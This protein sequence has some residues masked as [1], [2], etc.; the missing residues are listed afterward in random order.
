MSV[1]TRIALLILLAVL[2]SAMSLLS[3]SVLRP[4]PFADPALRAQAQRA[5]LPQRNAALRQVNELRAQGQT[6]RA[7]LLCDQVLATDREIFGP[8]SPAVTHC[9]LLLAY[10]HL[11]RREFV[12]ARLAVGEV[13]DIETQLYGPESWRLA[14]T[15]SLAAN[16]ER[17]ATLSNA[18]RR[19]LDEANR[20]LSE[21]EAASARAEYRQ[22]IALLEQARAALRDLFG[23]QNS[24]YADCLNS[25]VVAHGSCGDFAGAE[26]LAREAL[27]I[28]GRVF[29]EKHP[30]YA[31]ILDNLGWLYVTRAEYG[32]AR[33][34][35]EQALRVALD[36]A[37]P[38]SACH[39]VALQQLARFH[40]DTGDLLQA[41]SLLL[42]ALPL[43]E[44]YRGVNPRLQGT[45][46]D[47]LGDLYTRRG[48][49]AR[50]RQ[51]LD[52]A[53]QARAAAVG[54][55]HPDYAGTLLALGSWYYR[56][57][58]YDQAA[59]AMV[60]ALDVLKQA[61]LRDHPDY[62]SALHDAGLLCLNRGYPE[63]ARDLLR[64]AAE[65][66]RKV[67]GE[68]HP[69]YATC[70]DSLAGAYRALGDIAQ[71]EALCREA[72]RITVEVQGE[73]THPHATRLSN[74]GL[75][76]LVTGN[77]AAA[78]PLL[79][80]AAAGY[81]RSV[82][83]SH[84]DYAL[85]LVHLGAL[86]Q[87]TGRP[88]LALDRV[89]QAL[90]VQQ[91]N[92]E[93]VFRFSTEHAM[94]D[95]L[96]RLG[97]TFDI[98]VA[99]AADLEAR[100]PDATRT[101]LTWALRRKAVVFNT[102]CRFHELEQV[103][104]K[105]PEIARR[106]TELRDLR[107]R[108]SRLPLQPEAGMTAAALR[109]QL[110]RLQQQC[111]QLESALNRDLVARRPEVE[112]ETGAVDAGQVQQRLPAGTALVEIVRVFGYDFKAR[113]P[114]PRWG[115]AHYEAFV[116]TPGMTGPQRIDLGEAE[117]LDR[118]I[119]EVRGHLARTQ[120][121]LTW[122]SEKDLE[123]EYRPAA[124][125]LFRRVFL[126]LRPAL[127]GARLLY[128]AAE[129]ELN[130]IALEALVDDEDRYLLETYQFAY[131]TS[132]RDL[133]RAAGPPASGT[134]VFA[135]PDYDFRPPS[136]SPRQ[137][138]GPDLS[139]QQ[140]SG[141]RWDPQPGA[142]G[143]AA[144][145]RDLLDRSPYG[146]VRCYVGKE[147]QE[148]TFESLAAPRVLHVA[149]HGFFLPDR[150]QE[151]ADLDQPREL[152]LESGAGGGMALLGSMD[153]PLRRSGLVLAGANNLGEQGND[154]T[155]AGSGWLT[156]EKI[157]LMRLTGTELVV[158]SACESGL[159]DVKV[160]EG[161]YGLRRA[162]LYAGARTLVVSLFKVPDAETR[163]LMQHFY[164][165]LKAGKGKLAALQEAR[166]QVL[167]ERRAWGGAAHPFFWA[168]FVLVGDPGD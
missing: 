81:R 55:N 122:L 133:L 132:G 25:L 152:R 84:P 141:L 150:S 23:E 168:S 127:G 135:G 88:E 158:L 5:W 118:A 97:N 134:A 115:P 107:L 16:I 58:D 143:E 147:A 38:G 124:Q 77:Y 165:Q 40:R 98:L 156:A 59:R 72:L 12:A 161:V 39:A 4:S 44:Q 68:R 128:V 66:T 136:S 163:Q 80:Q 63:R 75:L 99:I 61:G 11:D 140:V 125:D 29:G 116:L 138:L 157:A 65:T 101:A 36:T 87:A 114:Q 2:A 49:Y 19:R 166:L 47:A 14:S 7:L 1:R 154:P 139:A 137:Q 117:A 6:S 92:L 57:G 3:R 15:R 91:H 94:Q 28:V 85:S 34:V 111:D 123:A 145:V 130:R 18:Q 86:Y 162:F 17:L 21:A 79:E 110:T 129:G 149:T 121:A 26:P 160:G 90:A 76:H 69:E 20:L 126:P 105:D 159:G 164:Q 9:L 83:A 74:L 10:L 31:G 32:K 103:L 151:T 119:G 148:N 27:A 73:G 64:A 96:V 78:E 155:V 33:P 50:A 13:A 37:G 22:A 52:R 131:L 100:R 144:I 153:N 46:L 93:R 62:A 8:V 48:D 104:G 35:L 102:R 41:E 106:A 113:A 30:I 56:T 146:P 108:V 60:A 70:L 42:Q 109:E 45:V 24:L 54:T 89:D 53:L 82:G 112:R 120:R 142:A 95:Y 51:F 167:R 43:A 67:Q 71:A